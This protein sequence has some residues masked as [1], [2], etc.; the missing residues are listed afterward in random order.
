[1][2]S[3][4]KPVEEGSADDRESVRVVTLTVEEWSHTRDQL[5]ETDKLRRE[6]SALKLQ[7]EHP[8]LMEGIT[9]IHCTM[10]GTVV[11]YVPDDLM[12]YHTIDQRCPPCAY[13]KSTLVVQIQSIEVD[14][15][16]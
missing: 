7:K 5:M 4:K 10:C 14:C 6:L 13:I 3:T 9:S 12:M 16:D 15:R 1:M 11:V 2:G 8:V